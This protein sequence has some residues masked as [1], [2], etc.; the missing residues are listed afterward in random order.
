MKLRQ[1]AEIIASWTQEEAKAGNM[2]PKNPNEIMG[3]IKTGSGRV[4]FDGGNKPVAYCRTLTWPTAG[5]EVGSL[6]VDPQ[7]RRK[8]H[9]TKIVLNA[10]TTANQTNNGRVFC[11]AENGVSRSLFIDLGGRQMKKADL[12]QEVWNLCSK[13]G[14]QCSHLDDF[15]NC[16]CVP[17]D[18]TNIKK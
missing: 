18:L 3:E 14:S 12:P 9:G 13:P 6:V 5:I 17:F 16:P 4:S 7:Q 10:I 2:L 15:P 8:G 1:Q 11:L